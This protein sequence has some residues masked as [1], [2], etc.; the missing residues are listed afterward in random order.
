[1]ILTYWGN[2]NFEGHDDCSCYMWCV[3]VCVFF[4]SKLSVFNLDM[5]QITVSSLST[6]THLVS[7]E[8]YLIRC[9]R[10]LVPSRCAASLCSISQLLTQLISL[11]RGMHFLLL[12]SLCPVA[13][14]LPSFLPLSSFSSL[15]WLFISPW[16]FGLFVKGLIFVHVTSQSE[17]VLVLARTS[18]SPRIARSCRSADVWTMSFCS[19]EIQ[20]AGSARWCWTQSSGQA[21]HAGGTWGLQRPP[22]WCWRLSPSWLRE[23]GSLA[24]SAGARGSNSPWVL[25]CWQQYMSLAFVIGS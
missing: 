11:W 3:C 9:Q 4:T 5:V 24:S 17:R 7:F 6:G 12:I 1:M 10:A 18:W 21:A 22:H 14:I 15:L 19:S 8:S 16:T 23:A 25:M 13:N 20:S 2:I